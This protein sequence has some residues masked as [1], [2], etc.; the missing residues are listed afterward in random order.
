MTL[1]TAIVSEGW[2][3]RATGRHEGKQRAR[4]G[5]SEG[6]RKARR[7]TEGAARWL[8]GPTEGTKGKLE[9]GGRAPEA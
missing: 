9:D 7:E 6:H 2:A 5:G 8:G 4:R 3:Q 1:D